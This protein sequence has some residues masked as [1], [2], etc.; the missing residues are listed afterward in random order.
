MPTNVYSTFEKIEKKKPKMKL[1]DVFFNIKN[2]LMAKSK[3]T[4]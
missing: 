2:K 1:S 4:K 3:K